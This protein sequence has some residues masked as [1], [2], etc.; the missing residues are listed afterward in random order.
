MEPPTQHPPVRPVLPRDKLKKKPFLLLLSAVL[1]AFSMWFF[2]ERVWAPPEGTHLSDLYSRWYGSRELLL[3]GRDPY[4]SA[5][6]R[7][8]QIWAYGHPVDPEHPE[9]TRDEDRFAYPVYVAFIL[10]PTVGLPFAE[11]QTVFRAVLPLLALAT[12]FLWIFMLRWHCR[13]PELG[14][15]IFLS[16]GCFPMLESIYLQQPV[17]LSAV[18]L[19]GAGAALTAEWLGVAGVLLALATIKPQ[20]VLV[21][22]LWLLVW[23]FCDWQARKKLIW[24]FVLT[25]IVLVGGGEILLP[26]WIGKF[27]AGAVSY[28]SYTGSASILTLLFTKFGGGS[29]QAI[30]LVA[31]AFVAWR[32]RHE[33]AGSLH[34]HF[35]FCA[36]LV[37]TLVVIPTIY[38]T[39]QVV[40]LPAVFFLQQNFAR[41]WNLGRAARLGYV[42]AWSLVGWQWAG[43]LACTLA[44]LFMPISAIRRWWLV[45][46]DTIFLIPLG[47]LVLFMIWTPSMLARCEMRS[48]G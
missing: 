34:F 23:A 3:H 22:S 32:L 8:V 20:L 48:T 11:V 30:L 18:F 6:T 2:V 28:R 33:T 43:S 42:A 38:P 7:E 25:M 44:G 46:L 15:A 17:L 10:A 37:T 39:G 26:G 41:F 14:V 21:L 36:V 16:F 5:V 24:G 1:L 29:A 47:L 12:I 35:V 45:P 40:L 31:L 9:G 19:A 27:A 13:L 4:G